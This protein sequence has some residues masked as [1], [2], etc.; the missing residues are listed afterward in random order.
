MQSAFRALTA[1]LLTLVLF[2]VVC[3]TE[4]GFSFTPY[5]S[6]LCM[7]DLAA[8]ATSHCR[9]LQLCLCYTANTRHN[10][11]KLFTFDF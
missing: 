3:P 9:Q 11:I 8:L 2:L 5:N 4:L 6:T 10:L 7:I 1:L